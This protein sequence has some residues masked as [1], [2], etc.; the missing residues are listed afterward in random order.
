MKGYRLKMTWLFIL[1]VTISTALP[2]YSQECKVV[3]FVYFVESDYNFNQEDKDAIASHALAF[4]QYWYEQLGVTFYLNDPMVE[5]IYA[6]H[7][8]SW[9]INTPDGIHGDQARWYRLGNIKKEVYSK[10]NIE[11]FDP[12]NR[13]VNYPA[14]RSD[15]KVGANF[16]GAW[17]DADDMWCISGKSGSFPFDE[18]T[19]A[20]CLGHVVH[21]F[22]HVLGLPHQGP[23]TDCMQFGFYNNTGGSGMCD[24]SRENVDQIL[25][26][27]DNTGWFEAIPG[28]ICGSSGVVCVN[29]S[30]HDGVC[31][32]TDQCP[33]F[34]D[35][36]IG[37][38]CDDGDDATTDDQYINAGFAGCRCE[39]KVVVG[40]DEK[41]FE[42]NLKIYPNPSFNFIT[43]ESGTYMDATVEIISLTGKIWL[44]K[45]A[46]NRTE[47]NL[48]SLPKGV[49]ILR[50]CHKDSIIQRKIIRR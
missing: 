2:A 43:V 37:T 28:Q 24:F 30:D 8:S 16:G 19:S 42:N 26:D 48:A 35:T 38:S 45:S 44:S 17:M 1:V 36:L 39:G 4:Q 18:G 7:P 33:G 9:Y 47:L 34:D 11:D 10:L 50:V 21:E 20:H 6:D 3:R 31:N 23:R 22:G 25:A 14:S 49:Y 29:D 40:V 27:S 41:A 46:S 32:P 5:V 13:V 15:G 12:N